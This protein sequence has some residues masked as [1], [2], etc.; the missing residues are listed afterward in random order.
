[1]HNHHQ[2]TQGPMP[3]SP[4]ELPAVAVAALLLLAGAH[5]RRLSLPSP[6]PQDVFAETGASSSAAYALARRLDEQLHA[7]A[8]PAGRPKDPPPAP[9]PPHIASD[10]ID[11]LMGHPGAVCGGPGHRRYADRLR[12]LVLELLEGNK[13]V[14]L[15]STANAIRIPL[16]TLKDWLAGGRAAIAV[17]GFVS[18]DPGPRPAQI[19]TVLDE[20]SR[21]DGNFVAFCEHV[22]QHCRLPFGKTLLCTILDAEGV[23]LKKTRPG[24]SPDEDALRGRFQTF[25]PH[26]QWVQDGWE[27]PVVVDGLRFTFNVELAVDAYSGAFVGAGISRHE[28]SEVVIAAV[29]DGIAAAGHGPIAILLDN[30]AC[31]HTSEVLSE[32]DPALVIPATLRRPQNK[33]HI[34]GGFGL[35]QPTLEGLDLRIYDDPAATATSFL[36]ALITTA[37]RAWNGRP[38]K[39]RNLRS[40]L[41]LLEDRPTEEQI[42]AARAQLQELLARQKAARQT[43]AARQNPVVRETIDAAYR[44]LGLSDPTG[45]IL[46][47]TASYGLA[48]VVEGIGIWEGKKN[49]GTLP[50]AVGADYLLGIVRNVSHEW[51]SWEIAL[52]LWKLREQA[53]DDLILRLRGQCEKIDH[54]IDEHGQQDEDRIKAYADRATKTSSRSERFFWLQ[55]T[56][57]AIDGATDQPGDGEA[58]FRLAARR[59]AATHALP[60]KDRNAAVR[61]LAARCKPI[62]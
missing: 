3:S 41:D 20:W 30:K 49:A 1:M 47:A 58:L 4:A 23:R 27:V 44:R 28:D 56:A 60:P 10:F 16:G 59:I 32:L 7:L 22:Q 38:R 15:S 46:T 37:G 8:K 9:A 6:G 34:E 51:E 18:P 43:R 14:P 61:F 40:R 33:A 35:L 21:W 42:A 11:F 48:A 50:E 24:R 52:A 57:D 17:P 55:A 25:F 5:A 2:I 13:E 19:A 62:D 36:S 31:N 29:K 45:N 39:D 53:N 26:A 12:L 54:D